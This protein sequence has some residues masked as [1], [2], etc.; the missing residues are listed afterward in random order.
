MLCLRVSTSYKQ[1]LNAC[2]VLQRS[3]CVCM[4]QTLSFVHLS[5]RVED[6]KNAVQDKER[7]VDGSDIQQAP[8]EVDHGILPH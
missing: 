8:E 1:Y 7:H 3:N 5:I 4:I 2:F 6:K